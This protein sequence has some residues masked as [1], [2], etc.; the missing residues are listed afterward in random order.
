MQKSASIQPR[1]TPVKI[2]LAIVSEI[3]R[4]F[5]R[6]PKKCEIH[7]AK[8][9]QLHAMASHQRLEEVENMRG[10]RLGGG[11]KLAIASDIFKMQKFSTK[12]NHLKPSQIVAKL[13]HQ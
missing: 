6:N 4:T 11:L 7:G 9:L 12:S 1:T 10:V 8:T 5:P 2:F 3:L 13:S